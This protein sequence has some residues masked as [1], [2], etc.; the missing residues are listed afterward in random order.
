MVQF[1]RR[2][3]FLIYNQ[4]KWFAI[5]ILSGRYP[6][7]RYTPLFAVPIAIGITNSYSSSNQFS[8]SSLLPHRG[9]LFIGKKSLPMPPDS[10]RSLLFI[11]KLLQS[12]VSCYNVSINRL[13]LRS[14]RFNYC[15]MIFKL[16]ILPVLALRQHIYK[17]N[18]LPGRDINN[19]GNNV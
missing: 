11:R 16:F 13:L 18:G 19:T 1:K 15:C 9:I 4:R 17:K 8:I 7:K 6:A 10:V 12:C 14:F 2:K 3:Y 5:L